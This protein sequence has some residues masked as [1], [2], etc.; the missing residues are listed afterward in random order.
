MLYVLLYQDISFLSTLV[1]PLPQD[2]KHSCLR[3]DLN[4]EPVFC[5][6]PLIYEL[7]NIRFKASK[8]RLKLYVKNIY[9]NIIYWRKK[10]D[11]MQC[12][13]RFTANI[14]CKVLLLNA[15][16][17]GLRAGIK[18]MNVMENKCKYR[19]ERGAPHWVDPRLLIYIIKWAEENNSVIA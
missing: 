11:T 3:R 18:Q 5:R 9:V 13:Y 6:T 15:L 16:Y 1:R 12:V 7:N 19:K 4:S 17:C 14:L 8:S 2:M 10:I